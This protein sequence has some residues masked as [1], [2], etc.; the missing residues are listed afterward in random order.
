MTVSAASGCGAMI[1][2]RPRLRMP[3]FSA[4]MAGSVSPRNFSW[5][6][7]TAVI[8]VARGSGMTLVASSR[9]PSPTSRRS[10]SAGWRA[11]T[12]RGGRS[13]DLELRDRPAAIHRLD[14]E[15]GVRQLIL[16]DEAAATDCPEPNALVEADEMRRGVDM[17]LPPV[18]FEHRPHE[19]GGRPLAVGAGDVD[20]RRQAPLGMAEIG[21]QHIDPLER[22]IDL[23]R[24]QMEQALQDGV[25]SFHEAAA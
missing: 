15:E 14:R 2:G 16:V 20:H 5:S 1:P 13:G 3:A 25:R 4:A 7:D 24:V 18:G 8:T 12:S 19:G 11:K 17:H 21:H 10:T 6:I 23:A 9:P 22:E